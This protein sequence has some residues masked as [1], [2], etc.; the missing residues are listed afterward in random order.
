MIR[1]SNIVFLSHI[2][3]PLSTNQCKL[4][5]FQIHKARVRDIRWHLLYLINHNKKTVLSTLLLIIYK[6]TTFFNCSFR[7]NIRIILHIL[8]FNCHTK[9]LLKINFRLYI[10]DEAGAWSV[11]TSST[12]EFTLV[13]LFCFTLNYSFSYSPSFSNTTLLCY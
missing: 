13:A 7:I 4:P 8:Y 2:V 1:R 10:Y 5:H 6:K 9:I 3:I 12:L 11:T